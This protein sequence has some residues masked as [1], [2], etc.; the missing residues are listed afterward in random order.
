MFMQ[1]VALVLISKF[2]IGSEKQILL[3]SISF[4]KY[5]NYC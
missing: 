5:V 2:V 4:H 3:P 1:A